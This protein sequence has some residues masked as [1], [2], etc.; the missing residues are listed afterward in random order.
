MFRPWFPR[1][2]SLPLVL[3]CSRPLV[4]VD[5]ESSEVV[6]EALHPLSF[7]APHTARVPRQFSEY[8]ALC[9]QS[10]IL[11][12]RHKSRKQDPPP[13]KFNDG[14]GGRGYNIFVS[15]LRG[16]GTKIAPTG[17]RF[18]L[19]PGELSWIRG[20]LADHVGGHVVLS[21]EEGVLVTSP[22]TESSYPRP[23][24]SLNNS[25]A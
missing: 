25:P 3:G 6:Q 7:L 14:G 8:H 10:R 2:A 23:P 1:S 11:H 4:R 20:K 16:N 9:R 13:D 19:P 21:P 5:A 18:D 17:D 12:A 15:V 22:G 24:Q